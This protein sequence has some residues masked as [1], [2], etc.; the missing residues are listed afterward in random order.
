MLTRWKTSNV[1]CI[2]G[3]N[4]RKL[5][6]R[7]TYWRIAFQAFQDGLIYYELYKLYIPVTGKQYLFLRM[8]H[9]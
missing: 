2:N 1:S 3:R 5:I 4:D 8:E 7:H 6:R 9:N